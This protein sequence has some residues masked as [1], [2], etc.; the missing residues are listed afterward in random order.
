M[1]LASTATVPAARK[2]APL[3]AFAWMGGALIS[4]TCVAIAGREASRVL[5][6]WQLMAW[7]GT[8]S[9][10]LVL[11]AAVLLGRTRASLATNQIGLH[12]ARSIV[13]FG[14]QFSWLHALPLIPL[15][16]LFALEFTSPLWVAVLAPFLIGEKLTPWRVIAALIGFAGAIVVAQPS[17][18]M[19][20]GR[21]EAF[22]LISAFGFAFSM[23]GTK[24]LTRQDD[25]FK[26]LFYMILV[27]AVMALCVIAWRGLTV[28]PLPT[29][30]WTLA[31]AVAG[32]SAHFSLAQAFQRADAIVVAPMDFLRLPLVALVGVFLYKESLN[33]WV[34]TGG[35]IVVA[36]NLINMWAEQRNRR[37]A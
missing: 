26:I 19:T 25:S 37:A 17:A 34:L 18:S 27:Q 28:P 33:P 4:F 23:I 3:A 15:A 7:R 2:N 12:G 24:K 6:T 36:A 9:L 11:L 32:L 22:A 10:A 1:S 20:L 21:G 31:I 5:D 35:A 30:L 14:A 16:Q 13:H 29:I 8:F